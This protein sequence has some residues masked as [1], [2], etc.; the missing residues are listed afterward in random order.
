EVPYRKKLRGRGWRKFRDV[1]M[2]KPYQFWWAAIMLLLPPLFRLA[3]KSWD[4]KEKRVP[5]LPTMRV[6]FR[7]EFSK[8]GS[9]PS[10]RGKVPSGRLATPML[11]VPLEVRLADPALESIVRV[12]CPERLS[13]TPEAATPKPRSEK[14]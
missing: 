9:W 6:S 3:M 13:R 7:H 2:P 14:L 1:V 5:R 11:I 8:Q 10:T 12:S 4:T